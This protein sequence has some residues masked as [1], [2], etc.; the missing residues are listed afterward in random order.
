MLRN[1]KK[2][3]K[4]S[5][6]VP[7]YN[8]EQY[9]E[10]CLHSLIQQTLIE[11]EII[12]V[13]DCSS[14]N[15]GNIIDSYAIKDP[16]IK[17]IHLKK[18]CGTSCA[19]K[20]GVM[21]AQG[22]Y[23]MFCDAD[24]MYKSNACQRIWEEM[25]ANPVDILQFGTDVRYGKTYTNLEKQ[26]LKNVL[27]PYCKQYSGDLCK[28]C[29]KDKNWSFTLWNKAYNSAVCKKA[30]L[31]ID[32][33]YI[34]VA[35]DLYAFFYISFYASRYRGIDDK[36]YIYNFGIGITN[37]ERFSLK[38][39]QKQ[40][41][42]LDVVHGLNA[43][44]EKKLGQ[45]Q[46]E[47][48]QGINN[49]IIDDAIYQWYYC[50]SISDAKEGYNL[51]IEK[52]G[53]STVISNM[54]KQYWEKSEE[55]LSRLTA[56]DREIPIGKKAKNIGVYYHR[57]RN[58]GVEKVLSKLLFVWKEL[59][60]NIVL[61][62]DEEATSDDYEVPENLPRIILPKYTNSQ[63]ERY[64]K[65]ANY[66]ESMIK[67]YEI[68]TMLYHSCTCCVL[69]WD[70]CLIKGLRCNLVIETH[71]MFCGSMWYDIKFSS[72]L[73]RIYRMVDRVVSLSQVDV[74]FWKNYAPTY[75]IPNP[76]DCISRKNISNNYNSQNI[77]W[78]GRLAEEKN[79]YAILEAFSI[80]HNELPSATLTIVGD[81]DDPSWMRGLQERANHLN[82][83]QNVEFCGYELEIGEYYQMASIFAM[84]SLSESF[85]MVLAESKEYG[86]PAVMF[87][88]PNLEL[89]R[90]NKGIIVVP[91]GDVLALADG[92]I[93][94]L[95]D[96][97][98]RKQ[99]GEE[100]RESLEN[101]MSFDIKKAWKN[102]LDTFGTSI[103]YN[104]NQNLTL[105]LDMLFENISRG[106]KR[107]EVDT[108]NC[109]FT[110]ANKYEEILKR[111][112]EVINRHNESI[113]HQWEIQKWH[114]ERIKRLESERSIF[115]KC[116]SKLI[117]L[118]K[119]HNA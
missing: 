36:L 42:R 102:L 61:F 50:L 55:L 94:L 75:F 41:T 15:S 92:I 25:S 32:D 83:E 89:T 114:E 56:R 71:S 108:P 68:D 40:C 101:F 16:R 111:H 54:A 17:P 43:F 96:D 116:K 30:F 8:V 76:I 3:P 48:I 91:Q 27:K 6:I 110:N 37:N 38:Q 62:T 45:N 88:L 21:Q 35:E 9:L 78:V 1:G 113:N 107:L 10:E 97:S 74:E 31:E 26:N 87:E 112:E 46:K 67:K 109:E 100:A 13:D 24:D 49:S 59:G 39:F 63:G 72:Y 70:V 115:V 82:I 47:I 7:V 73:P 99:M 18:N 66:W 118:L 77:I 81:N 93:K 4:I 104:L 103:D 34:V 117:K 19:R 52:L 60:Y 86:L 22:S 2:K 65:R 85:S 51:L 11:I 14:D 53:I 90:D 20:N 44:S 80:V 29:F 106:A 12:C 57:M 33:K 5:I 79:P 105:M 64:K 23:I 69:L 98:L 58:G 95:K 28:A 84:T 119:N